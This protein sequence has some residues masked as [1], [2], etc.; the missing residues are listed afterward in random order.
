M[1]DR[2]EQNFGYRFVN[3]R[4]L[5]EALTHRS[6]IRAENQDAVSNERLEYLGDSV[7]GLLV[8]EYLFKHHPD[9]HE[10]DLTKTKAMLVNEMTLSMVGQTCGLNRFI[11]LS[12]DEE[13]SGGRERNS[14]VSD[15]MEST[16]GGI[17]L[18]GGISAARNFLLKVLIPHID[19]VL[20]DASQR[21]YKGE[22]LELMQARGQGPPYYEVLAE[23]G[24][25]HA[26]EFKVGVF[27]NGKMSGVG[28]GQSKKEAEQKAAAE[29]L[30]S[31]APGNGDEDEG[32]KED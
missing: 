9:Y 26:K 13:Q 22:L 25:D 5:V 7:L 18:D 3:S 12:T 21:N 8:A 27:T 4:I 15:A 30:N 23:N 28:L 14:I 31:I 19:E 20:N 24:P 1:V 6:Y 29:S 16:I 11:F 10:G 2:F 32:L 17:Y